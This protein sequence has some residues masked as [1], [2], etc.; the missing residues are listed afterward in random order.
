MQNCYKA[1]GIPERIWA[2]SAIHGDLEK[3]ISVHDQILEHFEPRQKIIYLG[4]Y[5]G[6]GAQSAACIDEILAFRRLI[7][8]LQGVMPEDFVYLRGNQEEMLYKLF[9]LPFAPNP[10]DVYLWMLDNGLS[11]TLQSYDINPRDGLEACNRG[12][13]ALTKWIAKVKFKMRSHAG[14]EMFSTQWV[15]AAF[16]DISG[17]YP[18]LFV[19]AGLETNKPLPEQGDKLWWG[20]ED[21]E[22]MEHPYLPFQKVVR[23]YD[24]AHKGLHLNCI[25][26]TLDGGCGFGGPLVCTGFT[27]SGEVSG[28]FESA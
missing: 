13:V 12:A 3:L 18:M 19:H 21:F 2:V 14:H 1:L 17:N 4:N 6:Y 16:T 8:S 23:G 11:K 22:R 26:A 5:T 24:P 20:S 10:L 27:A 7:L 9:Q 28:I 25:T 15:R